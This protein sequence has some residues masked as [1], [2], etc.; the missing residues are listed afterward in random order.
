MLDVQVV[1][2]IIDADRCALRYGRRRSSG[3]F[4]P[5]AVDHRIGGIDDEFLFD[6]VVFQAMGILVVWVVGL[7]DLVGEIRVAVVVVLGF[8]FILKKIST[9]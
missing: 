1:G 2:N 9:F 8:E 4:L 3:C 6:G 5:I 7:Q